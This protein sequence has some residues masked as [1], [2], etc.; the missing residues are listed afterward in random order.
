MQELVA[1]AKANPGKLSIAHGNSTGHITI[2]ALKQRA[3]IDIARLPYRSN[4]AAMADLI[5][6]HIPLMVPDF[7]TGLPQLKAQNIRPLAV[8]TRSAARRCRTSRRCMR[9]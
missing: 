5:A 2:E 8:L 6:G 4:P 1:F 7:G 3:K 9:R